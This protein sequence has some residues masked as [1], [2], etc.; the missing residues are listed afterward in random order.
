MVKKILQKIKSNK[1][2]TNYDKKL[3]LGLQKKKIPSL[4]QLAHLPKVLNPKE[5]LA[6]KTFTTILVI[7][8]LIIIGG[9]YLSKFTP[10]PQTGGE[11]TEGLIGIPHYINPIYA[12]SNDVDADISRLVFSGLLKYDSGLNIVTDLAKDYEIS[13][14]A[15]TYTFYLNENIKWHDG[16]DFDADDVVF[17]IKTIQDP[18]YKSPAAYSFLHVEVEKVEDYVVKFTL[19]EP[20]AAFLSIMTIGILP[21]HVWSYI[22]P[23]NA[24]LT[25]LNL[26]P[27]GTGPYKF[28]FYEKDRHGNIQKYTLANNDLYYSDL[29]YIEKINFKFYPDFESAVIALKSKEVQGISYLPIY[30][31]ER[32]K[33]SKNLDY[34]EFFLPQYSAVFFNDAENKLLESDNIRKALTYSLDRDMIANE[35]LKGKARVINSPI[36][37]GF[38]GYNQDIEKNPFNKQEARELLEEINW[39]YADTDEG[40]SQFRQKGDNELSI[41]LTTVD[42]EEF[43]KIAEEIKKAWELIGVKT[44]LQ[45]VSGNDIINIFINPR[46]YEALLY[47]VIVGS[48][49]DPYPF[50][51]SSQREA[52][53]LNLA[54]YYN[55]QA[56]KVIEEA[57]KTIDPEKRAEKYNHFQNILIK[58]L[59]AIFMFNPTWTYVTTNKIKGITIQSIFKPSDRFIEA[60]K[61]YIKTKRTLQ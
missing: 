33:S 53:G 15:L 60:E 11:Y 37:P 3:L 61:W 20:Y 5:S 31:E 10:T 52:P 23:S 21:E 27:I 22:S 2:G 49:P 45:I 4:K 30:Y 57:R 40:K 59:P 35:V 48:D 13:G 43:I 56:D 19:Q 41:T 36:L 6:L 55:K 16:T 58:D 46:N 51:H 54:N 9:F 12:S 47:S 26:Q 14:D 8:I 44:E 38:V 18:S 7:S 24:L 1:N 39:V 25:D 42:Q 50:W 34:H 29:P 28:D 32:L 17:T